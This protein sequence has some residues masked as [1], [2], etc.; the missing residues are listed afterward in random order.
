MPDVE[1]RGA[2]GY[3]RKDMLPRRNRLSLSSQ[4]TRERRF[5][6][7]LEG[8]FLR[9][10]FRKNSLPYARCAIVVS[11]K[12]VGLATERNYT[13]RTLGAC[14]AKGVDKKSGY[15]ICIWVKKKISSPAK[16]ELPVLVRELEALLAKV[17]TGGNP[18]HR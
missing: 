10:R 2:S 11:K 13:K 4:T 15:D 7:F 12:A 9:V 18:I 3:L 14:I 5:D 6:F 8:E 1:R 16:K 17:G